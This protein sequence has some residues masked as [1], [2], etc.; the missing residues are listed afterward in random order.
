M[1]RNWLDNSNRSLLFVI[2][3]T[4]GDQAFVFL[5]FARNSAEKVISPLTYPQGKAQEVKTAALRL[6]KAASKQQ[7]CCLG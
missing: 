6:G 3:V 2:T 1:S 7:G 4:T 5:S